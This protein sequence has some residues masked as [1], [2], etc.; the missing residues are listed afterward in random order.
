M[1]QLVELKKKY[2][3]TF[4]QLSEI[5]AAERVR[6]VLVVDDEENSIKYIEK[7]IQ[8]GSYLE[9]FYF[10]TSGFRAKLILK[11]KKIDILVTDLRMPEISGVELIE[12]ARRCN[13]GIKIITVTAHSDGFAPVERGFFFKKPVDLGLL[14]AAISAA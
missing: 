14:F 1:D 13:P 9:K 6:R 5:L 10:E 4:R 2:E 8:A 7:Y 3:G 11:S 12:I